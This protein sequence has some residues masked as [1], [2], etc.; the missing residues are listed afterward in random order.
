[1][2]I[3]IVKKGILPSNKKPYIVVKYPGSTKVDSLMNKYGKKYHPGVGG[4]VTQKSDGQYTQV[5]Y[6]RQTPLKSVKEIKFKGYW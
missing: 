5:L 1:M 4:I 2:T 3:K 6:K